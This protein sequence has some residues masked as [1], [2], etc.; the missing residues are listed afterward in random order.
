MTLVVRVRDTGIGLTPEAL[1]G[2]FNLFTQVDA[3]RRPEPRRAGDRAGAGQEPGRAARRQRLGP[4]RRAGHRQR[5]H[6]PAADRRGQPRRRRPVARGGRDG[7][8]PRSGRC[9]C[10][11]SRRGG[12]GQMLARWMQSRG[13]AVEPRPRRPARTRRGVHVAAAIRAPGS[14]P[15]RHQRPGCRAGCVRQAGRSPRIVAMT[16]SDS[17]KDRARA[18]RPGSMTSGSSRST[19][20]ISIV[21]SRSATS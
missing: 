10:S 15:P 9:A 18:R 5:V 4:Q 8:A 2:L 20:K 6:R 7:P 11:S 13:H 12:S 19:S 21:G 17:S 14:R 1:A 16:A 3:T